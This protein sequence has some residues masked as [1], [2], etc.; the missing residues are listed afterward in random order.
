MPLVK[1][2]VDAGSEDIG[3]KQDAN[4]A[5]NTLEQADKARQASMTLFTQAMISEAKSIIN[6]AVSNIGN[7]TGDSIRQENVQRNVG[8][9]QDLTTIALGFKSGG[10]SGA[11]IA[12]AGITLNK[13]L[14]I[15]SYFIEQRHNDIERDY[16][17]ERSG[18]STLNG[19]R[20]TEN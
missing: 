13:G 6:Y 19:S 2:R 15:A 4:Q 7:L 1:I 16:L 12:I 20:G 14:E 11:L 10:T 18:N 5:Q 3:V 17:L 9:I 8:Y